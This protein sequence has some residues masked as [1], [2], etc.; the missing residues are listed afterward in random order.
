MSVWLYVIFKQ[1]CISIILD[2]QTFKTKGHQLQVLM[3]NASYLAEL[4]QLE[5]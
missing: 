3:F 1:T 2:D 4:K 5:C